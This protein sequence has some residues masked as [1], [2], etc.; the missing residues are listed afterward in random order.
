MLLLASSCTTPG[1]G[2]KIKLK[3][4]ISI[5]THHINALSCIFKETLPSN[6]Q[7]A[8]ILLLSFTKILHGLTQKQKLMV[9]NEDQTTGVR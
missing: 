2:I 1:T 7:V 4:I 9:W 5:V 8:F 3:S 6:F